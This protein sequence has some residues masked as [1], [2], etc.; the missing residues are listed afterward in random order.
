EPKEVVPLVTFIELG[1][2]SCIPCRMMQPVMKEI[3]AEY[4]GLVKVVF[5]D[6]Y[7]ER[8]AGQ[9]YNVRVMPTQVFLDME[10][11]EFFRHE[12]FYP[13]EEIEKMLA[14]KIGVTKPD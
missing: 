6:L 3:Q 4:K 1:A 13:Q 12:G 14:E 2:E 7:K 5:H 9:K 11:R 8:W 10:G